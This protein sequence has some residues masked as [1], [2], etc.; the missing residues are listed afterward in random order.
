[1]EIF[2]KS[3]DRKMEN[4]FEAV[5]YTVYSWILGVSYRKLHEN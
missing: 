2:S 4:D 5:T 3:V 1:M